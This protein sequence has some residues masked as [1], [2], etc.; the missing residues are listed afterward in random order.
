MSACLLSLSVMSL[1]LPTAFHASWADQNSANTATLQVSRGTSVILLVIYVLYLLFQLKSH[2]YLYESTPQQIIDEES[3]PGILHDVLNSSSSSSS[4]DTSS[5]SDSDESSGSHTTAKRIKRAFRRKR[6][7][8]S[9]SSKD[10]PSLVSSPS[11]DQ[12]H[13][14]PSVS[15]RTSTLHPVLSGDEADA[16]DENGA[17]DGTVVRDFDKRSKGE[18][19]SPPAERKPKKKHKKKHRHHRRNHANSQAQIEMD[20]ITPAGASNDS[21]LDRE[22]HQP[23]VEFAD[24]RNDEKRIEAQ[25]EKIQSRNPFNVRVNREAFRPPMPKMLSQN[26]FVTQPS[27]G[28]P[29][30]APKPSAIRTPTSSRTVP[31]GPRRVRSLPDRMN[32]SQAL[33]ATNSRTGATPAAALPPSAVPVEPDSDD[34]DGEPPVMSRTAAVVLLLITTGLVALCAEFMVD[35]IPNMT[36]N[37]AVS[38]TFIGL[39]ILPIV[40]NAAEHVTAV[41]VA[42]KNKMD[43]AIGVAV[44]SS[45][46]IGRFQSY[47]AT[48]LLS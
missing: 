24:E 12:E 9:A 32:T 16:D 27:S 21:S 31:I 18:S 15:R 47:L 42:A 23:R 5:S 25:R 35:A 28:S 48:F 45:I 30:Q 11:A 34:E 44:G 4:S 3:H 43:L 1:L 36:N 8:S 20:E 39:I 14:H 19:S 46:Q 10:T 17:P 41:T 7:Q 29:V 22:Q 33:S 26:V 13:F 6:R 38:Q 40:G 37:S 2:A